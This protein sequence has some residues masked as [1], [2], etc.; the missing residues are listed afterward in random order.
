MCG[1]DV[2]PT[3]VVV[4]LHIGRLCE[5]QSR[6][7]AARHAYEAV[8]RQHAQNWEGLSGLSRVLDALGDKAAALAVVNRALRLD[9]TH[10]GMRALRARLRQ[11]MSDPRAAAREDMAGP[12]LALEV[13]GGEEEGWQLNSSN[14]LR[15]SLDRAQKRHAWAELGHA[16]LRQGRGFMGNV[17]VEVEDRAAALAASS[18][19][20]KRQRVTEEQRL[21]QLEGAPQDQ[22][23]EGGAAAMEVVVVADEEEQPA[24]APANEV[25][26]GG[27]EGHG[28]AKAWAMGEAWQARGVR[29]GGGDRRMRVLSRGVRCPYMMVVGVLQ[30][31]NTPAGTGRR[32]SKRQEERIQAR[33]E[34]ERRVTVTARQEL[35]EWM[36]K[37]LDEQAGAAK[38]EAEVWWGGGGPRGADEEGGGEDEGA[39][40]A[41]S[42]LPAFKGVHNSECDVCGDGGDLICC[43]TCSVVVHVSCLLRPPLLSEDLYCDRCKE[44]AF[45]RAGKQPKGLT[46]LALFSSE[47]STPHTVLL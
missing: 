45:K 26:E 34:S 46:D 8:L 25:S 33:E 10:P 28:Q 16:L 41:K 6:L 18:P 3:D 42:L 44:D 36:T 12:R 39:A 23:G 21:Q 20:G 13:G 38:V 11:W 14:T 22:A 17:T 32:L 37:H 40:L 2:D 31:T 5:R 19:G 30:A 1:T 29:G 4:W 35:A 24:P 9:A 27:Y 7:R 47:V 43:E 15:I